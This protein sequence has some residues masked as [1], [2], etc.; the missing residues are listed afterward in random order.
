MRNTLK[1][2]IVS[3]VVLLGTTQVALALDETTDTT[4]QTTQS[5]GVAAKEMRQDAADNAK[6]LAMSVDERKAAIKE[7]VE[8]KKQSLNVA[9]CERNQE[10]ITKMLS[11]VP[12]GAKT[13]LDVLDTMYERV[14]G[15]YE[16]KGLNV[17]GYQTRVENLEQVKVEARNTLQVMQNAEVTVDCAATGTGDQLAFYRGA[18]DGMKTQIRE[19][20]DQLVELITE[21]KASTTTDETTD[22]SAEEE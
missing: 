13:Q 15:F 22:D 9:K 8:A 5:R 7:K 2:A 17:D 19:Y 10:R 14:V 18:A 3:A 1:I 6:S 16:A 11:A 21:M 4:T 12:T 20:R